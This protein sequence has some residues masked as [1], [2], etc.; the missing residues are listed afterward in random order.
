M[1]GGTTVDTVYT[2]MSL[3]ASSCFCAFE[4]LVITAE[5][6]IILAWLELIIFIYFISY[7]DIH[8]GISPLRSCLQKELNSEVLLYSDYSLFNTTTTTNPRDSTSLSSPS[9]FRSVPDTA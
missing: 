3:H 2:S 6:L 1:L 4:F 8:I 7:W 9:C 5:P